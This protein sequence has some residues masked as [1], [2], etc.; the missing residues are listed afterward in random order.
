MTL[1]ELRLLCEEHGFTEDDPLV[2]LTPDQKEHEI[3]GVYLLN[4]KVWLT[5][6]KDQDAFSNAHESAI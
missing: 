6:P 5:L 2:I 4:G 1:K 3:G